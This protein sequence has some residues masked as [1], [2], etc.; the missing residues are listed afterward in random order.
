MRNCDAKFYIDIL[1]FDAG[2]HTCSKPPNCFTEDLDI[3]R[4]NWEQFGMS[5][6]GIVVY[7]D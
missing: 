2:S 5:A 1:A 3:W 4:I 7:R 6:L